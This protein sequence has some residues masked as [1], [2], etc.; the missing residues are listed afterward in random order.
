MTN[1]P[2]IEAT[3]EKAS[4]LRALHSGPGMLVLP[5]AWD[6]ASAR[7][8]EAAGF[9][10]IATTSGGVAASL[11]YQDHEG[12]PFEEMLAAA[13]RIVAAVS[14]PVTVDFEAGYGLAPREVA[15]R[16]V[17]I[18]AAGMN[19]EDT[20]H[21][22]GRLADPERQAERLAAVKAAARAA[23]ADLVLNARVDVFIRREGSTEEQLAAGLE[24]ARLYRQAG[25][26]CVYPILL[27]DEA[28]IAAFVE[29]VGVINVNLRLGG[30]LS[31]ERA[32]AL[33]VRR[34]SYATSIFR[35]AHEHVQ[36]VAA[37]IAEQ[38]AALTAK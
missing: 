23:G 17:G 32:S 10:A 12:A 15:E 28:M 5:N 8:F 36:R 33:G 3:A 7:A 29:A 18:G 9:P 1:A 26:D 22:A 34:V 25:V 16:L 35:E 38:T 30:S 2:T 20:D 24:R 37:E 31:L 21:R 11:G 4:A 19:L 13:R 14:V 27:A 6:A